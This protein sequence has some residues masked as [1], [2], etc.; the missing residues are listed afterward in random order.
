MGRCEEMWG[1]VRRCDEVWGGV[2]RCGKEMW[3]G[4]TGLID[5]QK[6]TFSEGAEI[7]GTIYT[8]VHHIDL[9]DVHMAL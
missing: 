8:N 5:A 6:C 4:G 1:G 9:L 3:G 7:V 2:G